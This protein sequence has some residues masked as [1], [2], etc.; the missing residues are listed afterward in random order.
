MALAVPALRL[1]GLPTL[2]PGALVL[3]VGIMIK[4]SSCAVV[5]GLPVSVNTVPIPSGLKVATP[6]VKDTIFD[7]LAV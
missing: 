5:I 1:I 3:D 2:I 6:L 7:C 4:L